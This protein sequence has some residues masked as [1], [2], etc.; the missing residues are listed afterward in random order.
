MA[1]VIGVVGPNLRSDQSLAQVIQRF[2]RN[3]SMVVAD[4]LPSFAEMCQRGW[5][6]GGGNKA[7]VTFGTALTAT[8]V[9]LHLYNPLSSGKNIVLLQTRVNIITCTTSGTLAYAANVNTAAAAPATTTNAGDGRINALLGSTVP[10][11]AGLYSVATL[12]AVPSFLG[13][14]GGCVA[15][16]ANVSATIVD[17]VRGGIILAPGSTLSVQGITIVGT[18]LISFLWAEVP[19]SSN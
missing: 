13:V 2:E 14:V 19:L 17:D 12:P 8:G 7:A 18:G 5:V 15:T 6:F 9:T 16:V 4:G 10:S 3:G 1:D 11:A